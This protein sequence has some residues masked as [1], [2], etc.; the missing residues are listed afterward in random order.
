MYVSWLVYH[1]T[2]LWLGWHHSSSGTYLP[3]NF[4][5]EICQAWCGM[6]RCGVVPTKLKNRHL[7][8]K[9]DLQCVILQL[10]MLT[11]VLLLQSVLQQPVPLL[12]LQHNHIQH[13][14]RQWQQVVHKYFKHLYPGGGGVDHNSQ[15]KLWVAMDSYIFT[16][17][18]AL[19]ISP[20]NKRK[21]GENKY[22]GRQYFKMSSAL[23]IRI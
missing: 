15:F 20:Q 8:L 16:V 12:Q 13:H 2:I 19:D 17:C 11:Y 6:V 7:T 1:L 9:Q 21:S 3:H 22:K 23:W 18:I 5:T 4:Y 10:L 14:P